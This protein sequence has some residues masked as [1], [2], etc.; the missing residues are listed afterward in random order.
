MPK[1]IEV[2]KDSPAHRAGIKEGDIL[3]HVN[4][5]PI[6]DVLDYQYHTT[7][8]DTLRITFTREGKEQHVKVTKDAYEDLGLEFEKPLL[9][10]VHSCRNNCIFCF[11][12]QLPKGLRETLYFKDDDLKLSFLLGNYIT[13][14]NLTEDDIN[15]II[16]LKISPINVSVHATDPQVRMTMLNNRFAG[17]C[18]ETL[19]KL[20]KGGITVNAQIVVCP[21]VNDRMVLRET[22]S[23]LCTL[24]PRL[25]SVSV[26]PVGLTKYREGLFDLSPVDFESANEIL[27]MCAYFGDKMQDEY[28]RRLIFPADELFILAKKPLPDTYYYEDFP[29]L[30]N[31]VGMLAL[32][33]EEFLDA[34]DDT[35]TH[36]IQEPIN[37]ATGISSAPYIEE[38]LKKAQEKFPVLQYTVFPIRND[39]LGEHV[40]VTGLITGQ[41]LINQLKCREICG[42]IL[43]PEE[44]LRFEKD[45]FLD[46]TTISDVETALGCKVS[47]V[48]RS[49][50][51]LL[52]AI[53]Q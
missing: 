41:D 50:D 9:D 44:M 12:D 31:G 30:E 51:A 15:R 5:R 19:R 3:T 4:K 23:D 33:K 52:K 22:L 8:D 21:G 16:K 32:L 17:S 36:N 42:T 49:G 29:Q 34:L 43:L 38:L 47:L 6:T 45:C 46:D 10:D 24:Y 25:G 48:S 20:T 40:T 14:T 39:F 7:S 13:L 26:V 18:F 53:L 2:I 37:I 11:I 35:L 1:I 27:D 28:G